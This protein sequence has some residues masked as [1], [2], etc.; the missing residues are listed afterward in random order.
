VDVGTEEMME[1]ACAPG[2]V[3]VEVRLAAGAR[4]A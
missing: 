4:G 2:R 3:A 1:G